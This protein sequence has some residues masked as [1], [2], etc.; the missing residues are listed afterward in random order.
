MTYRSFDDAA[1]ERPSGSERLV[2][3][4]ERGVVLQALSAAAR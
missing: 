1:D 4:D 3:V 2:V